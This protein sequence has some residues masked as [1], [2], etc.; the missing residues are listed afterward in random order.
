MYV[1]IIQYVIYITPIIQMYSRFLGL[2]LLVHLFAS[3]FTQV[4]GVISVKLCALSGTFDSVPACSLGR[5]T[6]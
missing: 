6:Y 4:V 5:V 1:I 2:E 3:F